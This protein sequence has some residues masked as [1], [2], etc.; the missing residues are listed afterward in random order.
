[1]SIRAIVY[2]VC[3]VAGLSGSHLIACLV[4][5]TDWKSPRPTR[6]ADEARFPA[7]YDGIGLDYYVLRY[8]LAGTRRH[9]HR[10]DILC[11][12]SSKGLY[13]FDA[14]LLSEKLSTPGHPVRVYNLSFGNGEGFGYLM[15]I[16]KT[17]D[18]RDKILIADL[19]DNTAYYHLTGM[20]QLAMQTTTRADAYKLYFERNLGFQRDWLLQGVLPRLGFT[21]EHGFALKPT[22]SLPLD[23]DRRTGNWGTRS[24]DQSHWPRRSKYP[25]EF[26]TDQLRE[27]FLEE[28]RRRNIRIVFMSIPCEDQYDPEWGERTA[29]KLGYAYLPIAPEGIELYD[30]VHMSEKGRTV[31]STRL[32]EQM[33]ASHFATT[34][35]AILPTGSLRETPR[36]Y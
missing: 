19:T 5:P 4:L 16:I 20:A 8:G 13:G 12:S 35:P 36:D 1:M 26:Q 9:I 15:E 32:A 34:A 2:W 14:R 24:A 27:P 11:A 18:L 6:S 29:R 23:R 10:A 7:N 17:L 3:A 21:R 22:I 25:F 31:F 30:G 28:C 33:L